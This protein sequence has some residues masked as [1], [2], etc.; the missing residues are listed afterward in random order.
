MTRREFLTLLGG[1]AAGAWPVIS[2]AQQTGQPARIGL[3]A[4]GQE[5]TSPLFGVFRDEMRNLGHV[6][7]RTYVLEFRAAGGDPNRLDSLAAELS[8]IPVDVVVTDGGTASIAAKKATGSIP[9]VTAA[10]YQDHGGLALA[11]V[12]LGAEKGPRSPR[13]SSIANRASLT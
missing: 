4:F 6:E 10:A 1:A 5:L 8:Q 11:A 2:R 3:L 7:G 13:I 9:G 12:V